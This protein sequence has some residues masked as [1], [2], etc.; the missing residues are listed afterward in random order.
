[1]A[2]PDA[3]RPLQPGL[4][5]RLPGL[6]MRLKSGPLL[7]VSRIRRALSFLKDFKYLLH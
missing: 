7:R 1:M 2:G 4:T 3:S 6:D 5:P